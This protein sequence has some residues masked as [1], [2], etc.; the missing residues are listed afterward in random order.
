MSLEA[1]IFAVARELGRAV[2]LAER[3]LVD[4]TPPPKPG[5][6]R[7]RTTSEIHIQVGGVDVDFIKFVVA[8][9]DEDTPDVV[10]REVTVGFQDGSNAEAVVIGRTAGETS[11]FQAQQNS[12]IT[13][14]VVNVDDAGNRSEPRDQ[15]FQMLDTFAPPEP[16]M[17]SVRATGEIHVDDPVEDI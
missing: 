1:A 14:R 17:V 9:P 16:G 8:V 13:V 15:E 10:L 11:E 5:T 3:L 2:D 6:V 12:T 4:R 7:I